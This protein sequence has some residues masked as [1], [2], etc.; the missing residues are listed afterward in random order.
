MEDLT[1]SVPLT[2]KARISKSETRNKL[3]AR[4]TQTL[5][6]LRFG[7]S[8]FEIVSN[9][10]LRISDFVTHRRK[11][12]IPDEE[13]GKSNC[14]DAGRAPASAYIGVHRRLPS[15]WVL[16]LVF[17]LPACSAFQRGP[18]IEETIS[19]I[20][21]MPIERDERAALAVTE[22]G[23]PR[24]PPGAEHVVTAQIYQVLS[25]DPK[26]R[27]VPDL[28]VT[29]AL[30]GIDPS[31]PLLSRARAL[32]KAVGADGVL[33]GTVSR[34]RERIGA[35]YGAREPAAVSFA[36]QLLYVPEGKILWRGSFDGT[37]QPLTENLFNWWQFWRGGPRW[38]TAQEFTGLA[39]ERT[40]DDLKAKLN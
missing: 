13:S 29:Q 35:K 40:L 24:L 19:R 37:Q 8:D 20:A 3:E 39:V 1:A 11:S 14:L 32:G 16:A 9:F 7:H 15:I 21:V 36:L 17:A 30:D 31:G 38:F 5:Q 22:E 34:Y 18:K 4:M 28:E 2:F 25:S 23:E 10:V 33:I 12:T 27:F 26:W 6:N